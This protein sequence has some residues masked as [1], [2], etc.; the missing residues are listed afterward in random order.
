MIGP[1][2]TF[3]EVEIK[4][5][6]RDELGG[7]TEPVWSLYEQCWVSKRLK[8]STEGS[9]GD[10]LTSKAIYELKTHYIPGITDEMRVTIDDQHFNIIGHDSPF[11][12]KTILTVEATSY[13]RGN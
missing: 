7:E 1:M 3:A 12:A 8:S 2:D 13:D 9:S 6:A 5:I 4:T 11:R 10:H